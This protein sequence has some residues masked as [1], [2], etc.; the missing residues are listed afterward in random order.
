MEI[1]PEW[2]GSNNIDTNV[3]DEGWGSSS[4]ISSTEINDT[5]RRERSYSLE[6]FRPLAGVGKENCP[7]RRQLRRSVVRE[8]REA[9]P[10]ARKWHF[11]TILKLCPNNYPF[12]S[13]CRVSKHTKSIR[14]D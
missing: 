9:C 13:N 4:K 14:I 7:R 12:F 3:V 2:R 1:L 5:E 11:N 10:I 8:T 6:I